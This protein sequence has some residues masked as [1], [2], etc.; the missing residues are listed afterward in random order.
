MSKGNKIR[1]FF[2]TKQ[3][4]VAVLLAIFFSVGLVGMLLPATNSFFLQLTPL[5]LLLSFTVLA[6]SDESKQR[7]KLIAYLLFI[8]LS[9]YAIEV[10]GVHTGLL[11]GAY[12]Y[13]DNLGLKLWETPLIIG[14]NWFF[15]VYTTAAI[16]EK[17]R[18]RSAMKIL[19]A[20]L[21][22]LVYDIVMEQ[23]APRMDMWSWK[24]V[25]V[26]FQNYVTWFAIAVAFHIGLKLLKI[27]IKNG[28]ALA[29]LL[30]QFILFVILYL[31][32]AQ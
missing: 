25:A 23:V 15:L 28:L 10:A 32:L 5:A 31:F 11:F 24:E 1:V 16:I 30:C 12:S 14:A 3:T 6:L 27:K 26:P 13:G 20:S 21:A 9:S 18:M 7:G 22:M 4:T 29:V 17:T 19:L 8:Y 2:L